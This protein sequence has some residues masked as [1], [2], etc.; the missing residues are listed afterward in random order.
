MQFETRAVL[1]A[2]TDYCLEDGGFSKIHNVIESLAGIPVFTHQIGR[3]SQ[4]LR[5]RYL[6]VNE[7]LRDTVETIQKMFLDDSSEKKRMALA[8][9]NLMVSAIGPTMDIEI[10]SPIELINPVDELAEKV[11]STCVVIGVR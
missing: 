1:G 2:F 7:F 9:V 8:A 6:P 11:D 10:L 5:M 3:V 4:E